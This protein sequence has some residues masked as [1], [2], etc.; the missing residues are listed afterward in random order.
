MMSTP[1]IRLQRFLARSGAASRRGS[2]NLM[3]AGRVTVNGIV[4][5]QLGTKIDP[6]CDIVAVDGI[7]IRHS[8]KA[9]WLML[10]KPA[11]TVTTMNDP[12][13]RA[14]VAELVADAYIPGLFP[15]G[16]LDRDTTGLLLFTTDGEAAHRLLHPRHHVSKTYIAEV[17]GVPISAELTALSRGILLEDGLTAPAEVE[18]CPPARHDLPGA[19]EVSWVRMSITEG[20]KRQVRRMCAA[21]GHPTISLQRISFGPLELD[22]LQPGTWRFLTEAEQHQLQ[23]AIES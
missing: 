6:D 14:T 2:E 15:V 20:R 22:D 9:R 13:G 1:S 7:Q 21:I 8:D 17:E 23:D 11:G 18:L 10:H 16:R 3:T 12:Q 19:G 4:V 5:T